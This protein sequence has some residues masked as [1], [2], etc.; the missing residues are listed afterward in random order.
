M[1]KRGPKRN[2]H[3]RALDRKKASVARAEGKTL[4][5]IGID[6][7]LSREQVR[8]DL[9]FIDDSLFTSS[10]A[11][12]Q[13][14]RD[15]TAGKLRFAQTEA[16]RAWLQSLEDAVKDTTKKTAAGIETTH[17]VEGQSG[18]PGHIRNYIKAVE[19]EAKLLGLYELGNGK[20]DP[21][22]E[23]LLKLHSLLEEIRA[24]SE[25][26]DPQIPTSSES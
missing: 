24:N 21:A 17:A 18:S 16:H 15:E 26:Y 8:L 23:R 10:L 9:A 11:D 5:E 12:L 2:R 6:N 13:K 25:P 3:Q 22:A 19:A 1:G 14:I 20:G 7:G 4:K